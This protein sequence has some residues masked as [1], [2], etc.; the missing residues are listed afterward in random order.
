MRALEREAVAMC[1]VV[2]H[3]TRTLEA[4][5]KDLGAKRTALVSN[6]VDLG[7]YLGFDPDEPEEYREIDRPRAVYVGA[8]REWFDYELLGRLAS[9][10]RDVSFVIIGADNSGGKLPI[11]ANIHALGPRTYQRL[12]GYLRH[13]DIGLIPFD[14]DNQGNL[15]D[16]INPLKLYEYAASGLPVVATHWPALADIGSPAI[17]CHSTESWIQGLDHSLAKAKELGLQM[18]AFARQADWSARADDLL[19]TAGP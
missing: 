2:T 12:P 5:A 14:R 11:A 4:Y 17:L 15:V 16:H 6:G 13:A 19:A 8:L 1:H 18:Q 9:A 10:R 3:T 7:H